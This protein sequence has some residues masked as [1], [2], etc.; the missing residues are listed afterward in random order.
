MPKHRMLTAIGAQ[1]VLRSLILTS[2]IMALTPQIEALQP[3]VPKMRQLLSSKKTNVNDITKF[4]ET[5][6]DLMGSK[7]PY[8]QIYISIN[9]NTHRGL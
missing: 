5:G 7:Y 9:H 2:L 6:D 1:T 8:K 4:C 3:L